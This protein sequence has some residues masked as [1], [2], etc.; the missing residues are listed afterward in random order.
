MK[1]AKADKQE[2]EKVQKFYSLVESLWDGRW[3]SD[4]DWRNWPD[5]DKDKQEMLKIEQELIDTEGALVG[6]QADNRLILYEFFKR[7]FME[8]DYCGSIGRVLMNADVL[9]NQVCDENLDYLDF[10]Q[11]IKKALEYYDEMHPEE[12]AEEENDD[13]RNDADN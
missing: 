3:N 11:D 7:R 1:A 4:E 9:V 12:A 6:G 8:V 2:I 10:N 13:K 5:D